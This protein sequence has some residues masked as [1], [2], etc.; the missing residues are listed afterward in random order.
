MSNGFVKDKEDLF[1]LMEKFEKSDMSELTLKFD[2]QLIKMKK[3]GDQ[4]IMAPLAPMAQQ[5][6]A[7]PAVSASAPASDAPA[8]VEGE[9]I[10]APLVGTFYRQPAP[11]APP[12]VEAGTKVKAGD[13]LCILEAMKIMNELEAEF[14]CEILEVLIDSGALA[15]FGTPLYRV[16]RL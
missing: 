4:N 10:S 1:E 11:D 9:I 13:T 12:F 15:E 6:A 5:Y 16:K 2:D 8:A 7:A 3:G 14:D